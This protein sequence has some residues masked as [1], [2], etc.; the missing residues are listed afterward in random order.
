MGSKECP[1]MM[2]GMEDLDR[3]A[4]AERK[5]SLV[6]LDSPEMLGS[7]LTSPQLKEHVDRP[8]H[9]DHPDHNQPLSQTRRVSEVQ[10]DHPV[11]KVTPVRKEREGALVTV[12]CKDDPVGKDHRV[13]LEMLD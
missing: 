1:E 5:D 12:G 9:K 6:A 7:P 4:C 3:G 13:K 8:D 11:K 2:E 10:K